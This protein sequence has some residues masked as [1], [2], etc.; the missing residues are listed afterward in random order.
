[1]L[2]YRELNQELI[3]DQNYQNERSNKPLSNIDFNNFYE[4]GG[5]SLDESLFEPELVYLQKVFPQLMKSWKETMWCSALQLP[6]QVPI[7]KWVANNSG[8][9]NTNSWFE[10]KNNIGG[11]INARTELSEFPKTHHSSEFDTVFITTL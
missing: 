5:I 4:N 11:A 3:K 7:A 1:M 9:T 8:A 6:D 10:N 2:E